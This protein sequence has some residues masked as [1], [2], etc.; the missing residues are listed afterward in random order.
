MITGSILISINFFLLTLQ[1]DVSVYLANVLMALGNGI[2]WPSFLAILAKSGTSKVQ[3]TIQG[4]AS[5]TGSLASIFG[6]V[7]GGILFNSVGP[8]IFVVSGVILFLIFL[9]SFQLIQ[10]ERELKTM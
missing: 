3:G 1:T 6:L 10:V 5:S 2:M 7:L 8:S 9:V 4:Y